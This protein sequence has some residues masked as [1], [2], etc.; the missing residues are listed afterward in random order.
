MPAGLAGRILTGRASSVVARYDV[1]PYDKTPVPTALSPFRLT[2]QDEIC[3]PNL[4]DGL[5]QVMVVNA[6]RRQMP[7]IEVSVTWEGGA[8]K[9][10]T[11]LKPELGNGYADFMMT[12][13]IPYTVQLASGSD[14]ATGLV[15]PTCQTGGGETYSGGIKL[16]FQ[17]P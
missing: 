10:F 9:F 2:G 7:G 17:Q 5:L 14:I 12:P 3:D 15:P 13:N 1:R 6:S 11:G 16:T 4:P 8:E